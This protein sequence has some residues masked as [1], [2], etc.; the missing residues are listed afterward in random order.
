VT[1]SRSGSSDASGTA[2]VMLSMGILR[3]S[4]ANHPESEV[5]CP[6][7]GRLM[8]AE[9]GAAHLGERVEAPAPGHLVP[10]RALAFG[11]READRIVA[12]RAR[13]ERHVV[14]VAAPFPHL[15]VEVEEAE[16]VGGA[17]GDRGSGARRVLAV[18]GV[19]GEVALA[20]APLLRRACAAG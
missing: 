19:A 8:E 12:R 16:H 4:V 6:E 10:P 3:R 11:G 2:S 14:V 7:P 18:P 9:A 17:R 20:A 13:V 1:C 15:P 5:M